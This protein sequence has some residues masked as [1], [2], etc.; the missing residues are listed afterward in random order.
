MR[1]PIS[2]KSD[3]CTEGVGVDAAGISV[4]VGAHYPGRS[5]GNAGSGDRAEIVWHRRETR[6]KRRRQRSA[7]VLAEGNP[8]REVRL[9]RQ[10]SAEGIVGGIDPTEGPNM[11]FRTGA[12]VSTVKERQGSMAEKPD[13]MPE[14]SGRNP[15]EYGVGVSSAA[16]GKAEPR[17]EDEKLMEEVVESKNLRKAYRQVVGNKGAAGVD[18]MTVDELEPYSAKRNGRRSENS[19]CRIGTCRNRS[20]EWRYRSLAEKGCASLAF[21]RWWTG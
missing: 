2:S 5:A 18:G 10:K 20:A 8:H 15:P 4:K 6:R 9:S 1:G 3:T 17:P 19:W 21:R 13:P 11:S 7:Y 14:G 16:A 12:F